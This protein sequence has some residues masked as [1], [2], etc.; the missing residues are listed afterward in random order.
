MLSRDSSLIIKLGQELQVLSGK[1]IEAFLHLIY[2]RIRMP[3]RRYRL[4]LK[5]FGDSQQQFIGCWFTY[6]SQAL[7]KKASQALYFTL[8]TLKLKG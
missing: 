2:N 4:L 7:F 6:S 8:K 3:V 5:S 1:K